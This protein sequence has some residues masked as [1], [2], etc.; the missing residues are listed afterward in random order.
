MDSQKDLERAERVG[1]PIVLVVLLLTFGSMWA[2]ALPLAIALTALLIGLGGVG[3]A[4]YFL[5]MSDYV[6]NAASMIGLALGVDYAMF[7]V[8]RVR[9]LTHSGHSV[10]DA[11]QRLS[12]Y[13]GR[14]PDWRMMASFLPPDLRLGLV[15]RSAM[16]ASS[17]ACRMVP[18]CRRCSPR[19]SRVIASAASISRMWRAAGRFGPPRT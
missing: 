7:L 5:P 18:T 11:L 10:D 1:I 12:R 17:S 9:E 2:A 6:T 4:S 15:R 3:V 14:L 19:S 8:Q 13:L 16:V